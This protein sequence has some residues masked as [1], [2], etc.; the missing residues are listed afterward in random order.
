MQDNSISKFHTLPITVQDAVNSIDVVNFLIDFNQRYD[1]GDDHNE[2]LLRIIRRLFIKE[3]APSDLMTTL[4]SELALDA[5]HAQTA[6]Q[7][8][9]VNICAPFSDIFGDLTSIIST[10]GGAMETATHSPVF[11][12]LT[13]VITESAQEL[14]ERN[15]PENIASEA[16]AFEDIFSHSIVHILRE[17]SDMVKY[18]LDHSLYICLANIDDFNKKLADLLLANTENVSQGR[19]EL[20]GKTV[21][22][23]VQNW[24]RDY[25]SF[26]AN[27]LSSI[28]IAKYLG[29][30]SHITSL[31]AEDKQLVR[32]LCEL[33]ATIRNYPRS[34]ASMPPDDWHFLPYD[35]QKAEHMLD[36]I[37]KEQLHYDDEQDG[38]DTTDAK[39][40][41]SPTAPAGHTPSPVSDTTP[42]PP[43]SPTPSMQ[44]IDYE[45]I[46][47]RVIKTIDLHIP[48]A[49][50]LHTTRNIIIK[51]IRD[52]RDAI[53]T[54]EFLIESFEK[55]GQQFDH[56]VAIRLT[57]EASKYADMIAHG[58]IPDFAIM[59][60]SVPIASTDPTPTASQKGDTPSSTSSPVSKPVANSNPLGS[61]SRIKQHPRFGVSGRTTQV[62]HADTPTPQ[63][64]PR[65]AIE[66]VHGV[67]MI[68]EKAHDTSPSARN[69]QTPK[70]SS[71]ASTLATPAKPSVAS[72]RQNPPRE[73]TVRQGGTPSLYTV[74]LTD[75]KVPPRLMDPVDELRA[76]TLKDFRR[77]S[78]DPQAATKR[79][80]QKIKLLEKDS[81]S[82]KVAGINAWKQSEVHSLYTTIGQ[83]SFGSGKGIAETI[84]TRTTQGKSALSEAEFDALMELNE[85]LRF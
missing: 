36:Q 18:K 16:E 42:P 81:A 66:D 33:Y 38:G 85:M 15:T 20:D 56:K 35:A 11:A 80:Y 7:E 49:T 2:I 51:R 72:S 39:V 83:E 13:K 6:T 5:D 63:P 53:E 8:L 60:P 28:N 19:L 79:I 41:T 23:S 70:L 26:S 22:S 4:Q 17:S 29:T 27:N 58:D 84:A 69:S 30:S 64:K 45:I 67:P 43:S 78:N 50:L 59:K 52:I 10:L 61:R 37:E 3:L 75:V 74:P 62:P 76:F 1:I 65:L 48:D 34:L 32:Q 82:K 55:A 57:K 14:A 21:S 12:Y 71:G 9:L 46:A 77:L 40:D 54:R 47:D 73:I 25:I 44:T 68:V 24:L 31:S